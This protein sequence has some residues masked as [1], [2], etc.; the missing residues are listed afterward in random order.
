MFVQPIP[1][2]K[3]LPSVQYETVKLDVVFVEE[4]FVCRAVSLV[5]TVDLKVMQPILKEEKSY[6]WKY[7][8]GKFKRKGNVNW[9]HSNKHCN[10]INWKIIYRYWN[11][12]EW[13]GFPIQLIAKPFHLTV[14]WLKGRASFR[15][16]YCHNWLFN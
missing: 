15:E 8:V 1:E 11:V 14:C 6:N 16:M 2:E 10:L 13:L 4:K 3:A 12:S 7:I 5:V 9:L